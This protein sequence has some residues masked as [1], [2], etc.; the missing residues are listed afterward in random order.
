MRSKDRGN[1][2]ALQY[3]V[4]CRAC[5]TVASSHAR[6][7]AA[8]YSYLPFAALPLS[9]KVTFSTFISKGAASYTNFVRNVPLSVVGTRHESVQEKLQPYF[10]LPW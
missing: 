3:A 1:H 5:A 10:M 7:D 8:L 2:P 6:E 9:V 4:E